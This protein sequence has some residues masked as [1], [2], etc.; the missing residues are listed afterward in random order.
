MSVL[1]ETFRQLDGA[2]QIFWIIAAVSTLV[3]VIQTIITFM[4]MGTD[5]DFDADLA[6]GVD[7]LDGDSFAGFFSFRNLIN[8]LLG[9]GWTGALLADTIES[10][11]LLHLISVGVG[12]I[13]VIA[14]LVMFRL[15]MKLAHDGSFRLN[16][17]V[18]LSASVYLRIPAGRSGKGKIQVSVK[19]SVHEVDAVSDSDEV[20]PTGGNVR[21]VKVVSDDTLLVEK[22]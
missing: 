2:I 22:I 15:L 7:G 10:R 9:Y 16:E 6:S 21:I 4:G 19:G 18:G 8:F 11:A 20:I 1:M 17:C 12:L 13:F 3:F 5:V 14:F